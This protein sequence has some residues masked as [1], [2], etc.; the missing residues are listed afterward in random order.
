MNTRDKVLSQFQ[1][2]AAKP[3]GTRWGAI[4]K[5]REDCSDMYLV[6][7]EAG[8]YQTIV[9]E[10]ENDMIVLECLCSDLIKKTLDDT[11]ATDTIPVKLDCDKISIHVSSGMLTKVITSSIPIS[12]YSNYGIASKIVKSDPKPEKIH[13]H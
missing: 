10:Y 8:G 5:F 3:G 9:T 1:S 13:G 7:R 6:K 4:G 11:Y 2:I 12:A